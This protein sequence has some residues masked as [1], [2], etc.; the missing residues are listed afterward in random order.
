MVN[1][2]IIILK[3]TVENFPNHLDNTLIFNNFILKAL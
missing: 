2:I 1:I 3:H